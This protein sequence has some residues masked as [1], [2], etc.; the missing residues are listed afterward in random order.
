[1]QAS[2]KPPAALARVL[3]VDGDP[4]LCAFLED[5]LESELRLHVSTAST[6][7]QAHLE[8]QR[9]AIDLVLLDAVLPGVPGPLAIIAHATKL[10]LPTILMVTDP[11]RLPPSMKATSAVLQKPF[12]VVELAHMIAARLALARTPRP[13]LS[14]A[15]LADPGTRH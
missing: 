2:P 3:V 10:R 9:E 5:A 11:R 4:A 14:G 12:R 6:G 8:L 15:H 7:P 13:H 1:V